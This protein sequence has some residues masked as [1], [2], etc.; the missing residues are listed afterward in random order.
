LIC[1]KQVVTFRDLERRIKSNPILEQQ[2]KPLFQRLK[3]RRFWYWDQEQHRLVNMTH[4]DCCFNDIIGLPRKEEVE[5]PIFDYQ[6]IAIKLIKTMKMLIVPSL[7]I[8]Q[9]GLCPQGLKYGRV[10]PYN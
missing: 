9:F 6:D 8:M 1:D 3:N 5:K 10:S 7:L 4:H 2:S